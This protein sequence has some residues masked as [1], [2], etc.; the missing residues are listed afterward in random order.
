MVRKLQLLL[1]LL[2]G[3]STLAAQNPLEKNRVKGSVLV[4][5]KREYTPANFIVDFATHT[6]SGGG[7]WLEK[8]LS[9]TGNVHLMQYDTATVNT[10]ILVSE[11]SDDPKVASVSYDYYVSNRNLPNDPN[12]QEQWGLRN[13]EVE[14]A[15]QYTTG[16][17]TAMGDSIVV[18]ILDSGFDI[19]HE[20]IRENVWVNRGE[21]PDDGKDNDNN[22]YID[23]VYGWNF[24][25]DS[26]IHLPDPHGHSVAGIIGAKGNN[27][28]GVT[29]I[30][31][32]VKLMLLE[33]RK[34][35]EIIQAYEYILD[36]RQ[37]FNQT[38]GR[39]G[40]FV[41]ATNASF[42]VNRLFCA[43]QPLWGEMYGKLG[44]QGVLTA[45]GTANNAWDVDE[46]GDMPTTCPSE[47]L[48]TC[49]NTNEFDERYVGSAYGANTIDLGAPGQFS[50]TTK[51]YDT[52]GEFNG[53]SAAAPHLTG[54]IAL[55]YSIDCRYLAQDAI[56]D[57]AGTALRVKEAILKG[58]DKTSALAEITSTGGRLNV[59]NSMNLLLSQCGGMES[60]ST[61]QPGIN[62]LRPNPASRRVSISYRSEAQQQYRLTV[63]NVLG[64]VVYDNEHYSPSGGELERELDSSNWSNGTYIVQMQQGDF[65]SSKK[66]IIVR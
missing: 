27:G 63:F 38:E 44:R 42:G 23:D 49:L 25:N 24:V 54:T 51:P 58:V 41:V 47:Y 11:L 50:Y 55:L 61:A 13:I 21:I 36:Q 17:S 7:V 19:Y 15:W 4:K 14:K 62:G 6:R 53:N 8:E 34:V 22:G 60:A 26:P 30:N 32:N 12:F 20:D 37:R 39:Q 52:Y 2:C 46:V 40:S 35:S 56:Y 3:F 10:D 64:D 33:A 1:F 43:D 48:I 57:P 28:I 5:L 16:G 18:A 29:G 65:V 9:N 59:Y 31:W 45:A 66:F